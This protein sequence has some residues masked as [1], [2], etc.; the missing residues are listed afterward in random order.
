LWFLVPLYAAAAVAVDADALYDELCP[1]LLSRLERVATSDAK[2]AERCRLENYAFLG[3]ALRGLA[4]KL[5]ALQQ[6]WQVC[7]IESYNITSHHI[8]CYLEEA[9]R[10]LAQKLPAL[11]Q[12]W[13]VRTG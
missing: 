5:P 7:Y 3:E 2:Y 10:G 13:Q 9:L 12:H 1:R 6:H 11:Q 8:T 4:Q